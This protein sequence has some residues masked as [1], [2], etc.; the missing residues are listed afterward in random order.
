MAK[1]MAKKRREKLV[2]EGKRNPSVNRGLFALAD[3]R[4]RKTKTKS[5][6]LTQIKHKGRLSYEN[7]GDN[8]PFYY[9]FY[10]A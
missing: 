1:S 5:Q 4:S 7:I 8:R 6:K 2:R 10:S 9:R 3:M